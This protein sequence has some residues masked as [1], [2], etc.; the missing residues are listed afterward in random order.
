M[1]FLDFDLYHVFTIVHGAAVSKHLL[2]AVYRF[3]F[4]FLALHIFGYGTEQEPYI[5]YTTIIYI[6]TIFA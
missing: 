3:S 1:Q 4:S 5:I 2:L 6:S